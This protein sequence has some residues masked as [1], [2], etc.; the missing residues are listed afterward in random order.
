M[1]VYENYSVISTALP[2]LAHIHNIIRPPLHFYKYHYIC[3]AV[4]TPLPPIS[5]RPTCRLRPPSTPIYS[6]WLKLLL[7]IQRAV[8]GRTVNYMG[9]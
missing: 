7:L 5:A 8:S 2:P 6:G 9:P 4:C 3:S 1:Y